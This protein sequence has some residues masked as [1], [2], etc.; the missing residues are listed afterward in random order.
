[1]AQDGPER[2]KIT[3][4]ETSW[5]FR[6][7]LGKPGTPKNIEKPI[8]F[9]GFCKCRILFFFLVNARQL[10]STNPLAWWQ[11]PEV[12]LG[13][14]GFARPSRPWALADRTDGVFRSWWPQREAGEPR[15]G[16][17]EHEDTQPA[18]FLPR[19][20]NPIGTERFPGLPWL[21]SIEE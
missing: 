2:P 3:S 12:V 1:M 5:V 15:A 11:G 10:S 7:C 8:V 16:Q 13:E 6:G 17:A 21:G 20:G 18:L 14:E 4:W 9:Q 19:Y